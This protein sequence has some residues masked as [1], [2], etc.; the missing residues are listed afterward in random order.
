MQGIGAA[1]AV[2]IVLGAL[3]TGSTSASEAALT[4]HAAFAGAEAR[5]QPPNEEWFSTTQLTLRREVERV[6]RALETLGKSDANVWK[7]LLRWDLLERNLGPRS[8]VN[9]QELQLVRRWMYSNRAGLES[10]FF[11]P[12]RAAM[13]EHLDAAFTF[14]HADLRSAFEEH[15][16]LAR[17]QIL[18][19]RAEP[20]DANAA[21]LGRTLGW[22]ERTRQLP[23][24]VA[25]ARSLLS[26]PNAEIVVGDELIRRIMATQAKE[27]TETIA[28]A[29]TVQVAQTR[30]LQLPRTMHVRGTATT[31]GQASIRPVPNDKVAELA[32][33]Y[34]GA[35]ESTA[36]GRTGPV[37]LH[38]EA[39]GSAKA[40]KPVYFGPEG[41]E[42]GPTQVTPVVASR[43]TGVSSNSAAARRIAARRSRQPESRAQMNAEARSTTVEQLQSRLDERVEEAVGK[44][45]ADMQRVRSKL[46]EV[47]DVTAPLAREGATPYFH[48]AHSTNDGVA[49]TAYA[50]RRD[51]FGAPTEC[52][53]Q[54]IAGDVLVRVHTSFVNNMAE[55]ITG[56]KTL[57][58]E[59]FMRYAKVIHAELPLPLMVHSRA[60]RWALTMARYRPIAFENPAANQF[61][62]V[63]RVDAVHIDDAVKATPSTARIAYELV[64]NEFDEFE[65]RRQGG[66]ELTSDL[67]EPTREFLLEKLDAFFGPML[68]GG[69]VVVPEGGVLG[70]LR[71]LESRGV[72]AEHEWIVAGWNVPPEVIDELLRLQREES[73]AAAKDLAE[74][75]AGH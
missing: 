11:A 48:G 9:L 59:F 50:R 69:G 62:I 26:R 4:A 71:G 27:I 28:V 21:A 19:L 3:G 55:T 33:E 25:Q 31:V 49:L 72:L 58:D 15:T 45:R 14:S 41:I 67:D 17:R 68:N 38:L 8:T 18:T 74:A 75:A 56:G 64:E 36:R 1:V 47:S 40:T 70:A 46:N 52:P 32:L 2:V 20:T 61:V 37:T 53:I 23:A 39:S 13:D 29:E 35:V 51:Q 16:A 5:F 44:L 60:P 30:A 66:V 12:L 73:A 24:E 7:T 10:P 22:L 57:S 65:L 42:L 34:E 43:V 63:V 6:S 54:S